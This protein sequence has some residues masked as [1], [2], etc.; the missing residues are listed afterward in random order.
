M[1]LNDVETAVERKS[2]RELIITR[3]LKGPARL[4]FELWTRS[5]LFQR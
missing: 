1:R 4:V 3:T 5:E 2:E